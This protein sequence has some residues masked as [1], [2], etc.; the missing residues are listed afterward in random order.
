MTL[1]VRELQDRLKMAPGDAKVFVY[2]NNSELKVTAEWTS[3]PVES[4][5]H[6][7]LVVLKSAFYVQ[8]GHTF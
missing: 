1:T 3:D 7:Q 6:Q 4:G 5:P 2:V 8:A